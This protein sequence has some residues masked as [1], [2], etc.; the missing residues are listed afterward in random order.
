MITI[1][2]KV[3]E[4]KKNS[5]ICFLAAGLLVISLTCQAAAAFRMACEGSASCC[6]RN[7]EGTPGMGAG[8][9][10]MG[11]GCCETTA[12]PPCDLAGPVSLPGALFLPTENTIEPD[13]GV[14]L[15]R[16][17]LKVA[18]ALGEGRRH[19]MLLRPPCLAGPPIYLSTQTFLC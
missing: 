14:A 4:L 19:R 17:F 11:K 6:C 7:T 9:M 2:I 1:L 16:G 12:T 8:M 3:N 13:F 10:P 18:G 15:A 5:I